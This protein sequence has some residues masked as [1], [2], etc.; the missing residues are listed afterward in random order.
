M[1][2]GV[3]VITSN[4]SSMPEAAGEA[5]LL[6]DPKDTEALATAMQKLVED[7]KLRNHFSKAGLAR[8][9]NFSW[10]RTARETLAVFEEVI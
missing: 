6:I 8:V 9:T 3:P 1:A 7:E 4:T 2:A 10:Q 5:A